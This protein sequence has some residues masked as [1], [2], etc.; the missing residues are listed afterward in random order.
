[1]RQ[2]FPSIQ[3]VIFD[4]DD[5]L[6]PER[7]FVRSGYTAV[8]AYLR[9]EYGS[10]NDFAGWL[11]RRF[12]DGRVAGAFNDLSDRFALALNKKKIAELV[13]AYRFHRPSIQPFEGIPSLLK[14]LRKRY[15]LGILSDGAERMQ[16]NKLDALGLT[17]Y[18]EPEIV[19]LTDT[20]GPDS[21]KPSPN[22]FRRIVQHLRVSHD[23]CAYVADNPAKD[24]PAP[25]R[26]GWRTVAYLRDGQLHAHRTAP[27]EGQPQIVVRSDSELLAALRRP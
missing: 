8:D 14:Q 25:N 20:L 21:G 23:A 22:G 12:L 19:V 16:R 13:E 26:L 5:T 6:Y 15:R 3:A 11:W 4:I 18:F 9:K 10:E 1:M 27:P 2:A 24:F 17:D 7:Q